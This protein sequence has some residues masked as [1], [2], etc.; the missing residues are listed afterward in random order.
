M[1]GREWLNT[2]NNEELAEV[3]GIG[4]MHCPYR[5]HYSKCANVHCKVAF[6]EFLEQEVN[7]HGF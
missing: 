7:E 1:T 6:L 5:E 2:L 4:C 3:T